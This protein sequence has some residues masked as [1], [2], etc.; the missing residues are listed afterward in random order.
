MMQT[1]SA[2]RYLKRIKYGNRTPN[3]DSRLEATD[4]AQLPDST[5]MFEVVFDYDEG[6]YT[7]ATAGRERDAYLP[8]P[9]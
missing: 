8:K 9:R 1:R 6:H 7:G 5:W 3:R 2:N 4:P